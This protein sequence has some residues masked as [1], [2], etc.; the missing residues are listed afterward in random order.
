MA[1]WSFT[2]HLLSTHADLF[3]A[4]TEHPFLLA[5]AEG[6][7]PKSVLGRWLANDRLYIHSY[8]RAAARLLASLELPRHVPSLED[9]PEK[10]SFETRLADWLI[11]ALVAIRR[12]ERLFIDVARR[13][14][15]TIQLSDSILLPPTEGVPPL[16]EPEDGTAPETGVARVPGLRMM[17]DIIFASVASPVRHSTTAPITTAAEGTA[18][19]LPLPWLEGAITFWGTERCYLEA[20]TWARDHAN[21]VGRDVANDAD[22]GALRKEFI[23]NWSSKEFRA[24]VDRLQALID[25]AV[26]DALG[27]VPEGDEREKVKAELLERVEGPWKTLLEAERA[28]WPDL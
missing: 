13:Y 9:E 25:E 17:E 14:G 18:R 10:E 7:L 19:P 12:E 1:S 11:E 22:G 6:R 8:L 23:P 28:F 27:K 2:S 5:G 20:W 15:L 26:A 24:F 3:K 16:A 21:T 4:A